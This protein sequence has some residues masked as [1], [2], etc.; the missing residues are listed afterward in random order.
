MLARFV[1]VVGGMT[2]PFLL[3]AALAVVLSHPQ[4]EGWP[5]A[6]RWR[7]GTSALGLSAGAIF[8]SQ[9]AT[10]VIT[11]RTAVNIPTLEAC[12]VVDLALLAVLIVLVI[13]PSW[14]W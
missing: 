11:S 9:R 10:A 5:R 12:T 4:P 13:R 2:L 6:S 14:G 7:L 1:S 3:Y 8:A